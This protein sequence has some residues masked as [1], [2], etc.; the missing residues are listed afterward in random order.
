MLMDLVSFIN[1]DNCDLIKKLDV[2]MW[3]FEFLICSSW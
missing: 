1:S 3:L 2:K